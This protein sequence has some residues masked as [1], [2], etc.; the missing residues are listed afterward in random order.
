MPPELLSASVE[1]PS[2]P[3]ND[4]QN[5]PSPDTTPNTSHVTP[6]Y[7]ESISP[8]KGTM[9]YYLSRI[10]GPSSLAVLYLESGLL[11][12]EG[13]AAS[14]LASSYSGLSALRTPLASSHLQPPPH[15]SAHPDHGGN[16]AWNSDQ[17]HARRFFNRA[18]E[19]CPALDVPLLPAS[20]PSS[21]PESGGDNESPVLGGD[22]G[23]AAQ[24]RTP[25][26]VEIDEASEKPRRRR[27]RDTVVGDDL[28]AS[29]TSRSAV[30]DPLDGAGEDNTWYLYLPGLVGAGTALLVVGFLS[31]SSWRKGQGN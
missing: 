16:D 20:N 13:S 29:I 1:T 14:L 22:R 6:P 27:R 21:E 24:T 11:Y 4:R 8:M 9:S 5:T 30:E 19:L 17:A 25:P 3:T 18:R 7:V 26:P 23:T 10:G 28:A 12:L 31:F 2:T 15:L